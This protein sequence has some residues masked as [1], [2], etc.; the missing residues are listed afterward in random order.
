MKIID[1]DSRIGRRFNS[2]T[3]GA[4]I[5]KEYVSYKEVHIEFED[6]GYKKIVSWDKVLDGRI[7]DPYYPVFYGLACIG[8]GVPTGGEYTTFYNRW[9]HMLSRVYNTEDEAY[10]RYGAKGVKIC[11][12]W[13]C[14][15]NYYED[16]STLDNFKELLENPNQWDIDK[17]ICGGKLYSKETCRI[18]KSER[19][20]Q[21]ARGRNICQMSKDG[22]VLDTFASYAE[23][24]RKTGIS[25]KAIGNCIRGKS[26]TSGGYIWI[27]IAYE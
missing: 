5:V 15:S 19:N 7:K 11:D 16:I 22:Y 2:K 26:K 20:T 4:Y 3:S 12:R 8:E 23:A 10:E 21:I 9:K 14:Y 13:L 18:I 6:T 24:E 17:D 1:K 27:D 25:A